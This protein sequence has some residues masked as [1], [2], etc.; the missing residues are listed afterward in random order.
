MGTTA[1]RER[2]VW[3]Q[4][5]VVPTTALSDSFSR[6]A[7][8]WHTVLILLAQGILAYRGW[9]RFKG[10]TGLSGGGRVRMYE[11]TIVLEW[12]MLGLVLA[13]VWWHGSSLRTVLGQRWTSLTG[14]LRDAGIGIAFLMVAIVMGSIL[15]HTKNGAAHLILPQRGSEMWL[16]IAL[17]LTAGI[18]EE[19]LFRG[20]LQ[21]QFISVTKNAPAGVILAAAV[22]GGAHAYQ[23]WLPALQIGLLGAIA[24]TIA[25]RYRTVR[26]G[27]I[28][29]FLQDV[30]GGLLRH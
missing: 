17:S 22:F 19:A 2:D 23:G 6:I 8:L 16:W 15:P 28:E 30:L 5:A 26:P 12:V 20:Y 14:F 11:Q 7:P 21:R 10:L 25:Y 18:C 13:G 9:M 1:E 3:R 4:S 27:M 24:G 29:H